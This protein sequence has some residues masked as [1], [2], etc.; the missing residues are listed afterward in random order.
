MGNSRWILGRYDADGY[1]AQDNYEK[2]IKNN[3][4]VIFI[5]KVLSIYNKLR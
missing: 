5:D 3:K 4:K 2:A 1:F